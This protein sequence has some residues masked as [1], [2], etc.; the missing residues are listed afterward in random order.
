MV[1]RGILLD[2]GISRDPIFGRTYYAMRELT[3]KQ[4][5]NWLWLGDA[6]GKDYIPSA[7]A[8]FLVHITGKSPEGDV[9]AGTGLLL[10]SNVVLTCAHVLTDMRIDPELTIQGKRFKVGRIHAHDTID[11]GLIEIE[12]GDL[13][14][15][16]Y[17]FHEPQSLDE[18]YVMGFPKIPFT[19]SAALIVHRGEVTNPHVT[20]LNGQDV[21]LYSA[22]ARPGN[23][24]GPI[25]SNH[26]YVLGLVTQDL[27]SEE[28]EM[29]LP[30]YAG[31]PMSQITKAVEELIP[32]FPFRVE[33]YN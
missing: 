13:T 33:D 25:I 12:G 24:G 15:P 32:G 27:V 21:F 16:S 7:F 28:S 19:R 29:I 14:A 20:T 18:L 2:A 3:Q 1:L 30:F 22:I 11:V 26:G 23:S 6:V 9:H 17:A 4:E 31:V 5:K 10:E 8:T